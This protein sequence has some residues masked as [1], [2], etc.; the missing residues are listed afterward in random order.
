MSPVYSGV[1]RAGGLLFFSGMTGRVADGSV[2]AAVHGQMQQAFANVLEALRAER[3][4]ASDV[5]KV[6]VYLR[7]MADLDVLDHT[8]SEVFAE[9]RPART[10][11]AV[12]GL[13]RNAAVELDV[14]A[15]TSGP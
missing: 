5:V 6:T 1:R 14:V 11:V 7:D 3:L 9:P 2:P 12:S 15:V 13:P 4:D 10:T 8:F